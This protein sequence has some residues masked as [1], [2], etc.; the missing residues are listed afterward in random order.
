M[1][2]TFT[3]ENNFFEN[4]EIGVGAW[5]W[6]DRF[7]WNYGKS[8]DDNDIEQAFTATLEAGIN[9]IDTAEVYGQ[10]RSE[11]IIGNLIKNT[12]QP[13]LI[14][15]KFFPYPW[16]FTKKALQKALDNSLN[17]LFAEQIFLY[18]IHWPFSVLPIDI[19]MEALSEAVK[20]GKTKFVGISNFNKSQTQRAYTALSRKEVPLASNQLEYNLLNRQIEKSGLLARCQELKVRVIAYSPLAQGLLSGK[21]SPES[22]PPG[23]RGPRYASL[24]KEIRPLLALMTEIGQSHGDK[25]PSQVALNWLICKGTLPIPG[26]KNLTQIQQNNGAIGWRLAETEVAALDAA[27]DNFTK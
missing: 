27:S 22:P 4:I 6:G 19:L 21:Y 9:F 2:A 8:Y 18:Q 5:A 10:G 15:T 20:S 7:M 1:V 25:T 24:L 26:A 23:F 13:V 14:A 16:R 11:Q 17:R 3:S 12:P